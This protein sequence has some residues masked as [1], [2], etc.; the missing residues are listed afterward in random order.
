ME[1]IS[2]ISGEDNLE[3][4]ES[5]EKIVNNPE[6]SNKNVEEAK[7]ALAKIFKKN[8]EIDLSSKKSKHSNQEIQIEHTSNEQIEDFSDNPL[9]ELL[10]EKRKEIKNIDD[11]P[12]YIDDDVIEEQNLSDKINPASIGSIITA[13]L[14]NNELG[15]RK[16]RPIFRSTLLKLGLSS[17]TPIYKK[18]MIIGFLVGI[19]LFIIFVIIFI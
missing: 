16:T 12:L 5:Y 7:K 18:S 17:A 19:I 11:K 15:G 4:V 1:E 10:F 6:Y 8:R 14:S 3:D 13:K 9:E 2:R